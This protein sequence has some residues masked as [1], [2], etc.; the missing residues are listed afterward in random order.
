MPQH[1]NSNSNSHELHTWALRADKTSGNHQFS[2]TNTI[3]PHPP[4]QVNCP[5]VCES[6][7]PTVVLA[8]NQ[9]TSGTSDFHTFK[10]PKS[11]NTNNNKTNQSSNQ[12]SRRR[13]PARV[14]NNPQHTHTHTNAKKRLCNLCR[15]KVQYWKNCKSNSAT[16]RNTTQQ[17]QSNNNSVTALMEIMQSVHWINSNKTDKQTNEEARGMAECTGRDYL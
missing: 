15:N 14:R 16:Q 4:R 12:L 10:Q 9:A 1:S 7:F 11:L 2:N 5:S 17:Q 13:P 3:F 6:A 8:D